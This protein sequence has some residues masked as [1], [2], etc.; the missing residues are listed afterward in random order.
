M[1]YFSDVVQDRNG[2]VVSN[3]SVL[4]KDYP[5]LTT[6]TIYDSTGASIANPI[7]TS[8][9]GEY[10]FYCVPGA[11][12]IVTS[13]SGITTKTR[14]N[15]IIGTAGATINVK[16]P[17]Y[18]ATGDGTTNDTAAIQ[19]AITA[20][21]KVYFPAGTYLTNTLTLR[22][23]S[24]LFG[25]GAQS[26]IKQN[27]TTGASYG[28]LYADS[29]STSATYDNIVVRD[30]QLLGQVATAGF[31]QF[32]HLASFSGVKDAQ[33]INV[34]FKG[35]RGDG[36]Y[37]GSSPTAATERHNYKVTVRDCTFDGV[38]NDNR[39]GIS[40]IDVD[41]MLID[42]C[43]FIN[44]TKSTM[45]GA[46]DIEPDSSAFH[47]IKNIKITNNKFD[48]V[49]GNISVVSVYIPSGVTVSAI[50]VIV[51]N[52]ESVNPTNTGSFFSF[53]ANRSPT[54]T[55]AENDVRLLN[56][57]A[58][59]GAIAFQF[60]DG[61]RITSQGNT[62]SDFTGSCYIGVTSVRDCVVDNDR[63]IRC[64]SAGG[65]IGL[66]VRNADYL[67]I[68]GCKF[69]DCGTG[70]GGTSNAIDFNTGTSTY[71]ILDGND[72]SAPTAKTLIAVQKEAAH[73]FTAAT[74]KCYRNDFHSL[75]NNFVAED[76]DQLETTYTPIVEGASTP[77]S[78]TYTTQYGRY[79]RRGRLVTF[80]AFVDVSA[81]NTAAGL[82]ELSLPLAAAT[83]SQLSTV[84]VL[85]AS[86]LLATAATVVGRLNTAAGVG[87]VSGAIRMYSNNAN[88]ITQL[89]IPAGAFTLEVSGS[90]LAA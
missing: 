46:I 2:N 52:N 14:S 22:A 56:N 51:A 7:T 79:M 34:L 25:D 21:Y 63:F 3:A 83:E 62:W 28:T 80:W 53:I 13:K 74:N 72:F 67:T 6:A 10:T 23:G 43:R 71:V 77:G 75:T 40:V 12:T 65:G 11:Y 55:S 19:A 90:Y 88:A 29:L 69:I 87:G 84:G 64:G 41:N 45:P 24:F 4:V 8:S 31:S 18:S 5:A 61:K 81:P 26:I 49:G 70:G 59:G 38:N 44:C 73:T 16:E 82:I 86:G 35:F 17:P 50:N 57:K 32:E 89:A 60:Y 42:N 48:H 9:D 27:T 76:S 1:Q 58:S 39:N 15:V 66:D 20:G 78:P 30:L 54:S 33:F 47:I 36:L 68:K 37:I 85:T